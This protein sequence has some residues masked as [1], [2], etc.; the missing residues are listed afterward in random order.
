MFKKAIQFSD[1]EDNTRFAWANVDLEELEREILEEEPDQE[2]M[3]ADKQKFKLFLFRQRFKDLM[4]NWSPYSELVMLEQTKSHEWDSMIEFLYGANG[5]E[6]F[7]SY[8]DWCSSFSAHALRIAASN[9]SLIY[10]N[11]HTDMTEDDKTHRI[12]MIA[13]TWVKLCDIGDI[14]DRGKASLFKII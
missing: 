6:I 4:K 10:G 12:A 14:R 2:A 1:D 9:P 5:P 13:G 11:H 8:E 3:A 7:K